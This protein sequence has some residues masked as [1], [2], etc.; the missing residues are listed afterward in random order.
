MQAVMRGSS[1]CCY[2][3]NG[4]CQPPQKTNKTWNLVAI[5][6]VDA[7]NLDRPKPAMIASAVVFFIVLTMVA[8]LSL[9]RS[10]IE[11]AHDATGAHAMRGQ[12]SR[13]LCVDP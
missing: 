10:F 8:V 3:A 7:P 12:M 13:W 2:Y 6:G 1:P 9:V 4:A 11:A 5:A